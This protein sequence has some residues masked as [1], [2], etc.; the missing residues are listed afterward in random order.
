MCLPRLRALVPNCRDKKSPAWLLA[1]PS[2]KRPHGAH[3]QAS[4]R[5]NGPGSAGLDGWSDGLRHRVI[6]YNFQAV[7][8]SPWGQW[9]PV[10]VEGGRRGLRG[11]QGRANSISTQIAA[12]QS[13]SAEGLLNTL[14]SNREVKNVNLIVTQTCL[15]CVSLST[16]PVP[17]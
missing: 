7:T 8:N 16:P 6:I 2:Q 9:S 17:Y 4:Q 5:K 15:Y 1:A 10:I 13:L 14:N 11:A 12:F 3:R